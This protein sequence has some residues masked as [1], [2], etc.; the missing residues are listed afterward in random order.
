MAE[1][2]E[3]ERIA[4]EKHDELMRLQR[5]GV[6]LVDHNLT[7][8]IKSGKAVAGHEINVFEVGETNQ[9]E[10]FKESP[11]RV[12]WHGKAAS[13]FELFMNMHNKNP[14]EMPG[15]LTSGV[16]ADHPFKYAELLQRYYK[17]GKKHLPSEYTPVQRVTKE[18]EDPFERFRRDVRGNS[19]F[20]K[21]VETPPVNLDPESIEK[22]F[23]NLDKFGK[24]Q[25]T[26]IVWTY[27]APHHVETLRKLVTD[28]NFGKK[29][30][31]EK[32]Q[33]LRAVAYF[34]TILSAGRLT[35]PGTAFRPAY[36]GRKAG[37]SLWY[38]L[39]K[40]RESGGGGSRIDE[41]LRTPFAY[42]AAALI[43]PDRIGGLTAHQD[44]LGTRNAPGQ[45]IHGLV[46][47][48][49]SK[50]AAHELVERLRPHFEQTP[51]DAFPIYDFKGNKVWPPEPKEKK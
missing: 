40:G 27:Y 33:A 21:V 34:T 1:I 18:G 15:W 39:V 45:P 28:R 38:A 47:I 22:T 7:G 26:A 48:E 14:Y 13:A 20:R 16:G 31:R 19:V 6:R 44:W 17:V 32:E 5:V 30:S 41:W 4:R 25:R 11:R 29:S 46:V 9:K 2:P 42:T 12:G 50:N 51:H 36:I 8:Q 10:G 43:H 37:P 23:K 3:H 35:P 49:R 24:A